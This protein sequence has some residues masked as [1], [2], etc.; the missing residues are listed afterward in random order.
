V[1]RVV[2]E[3]SQ[4]IRF[5]L[6][7]NNE[8]TPDIYH[9]LPG[10]GAYVSLDK[11]TVQM[12]MKKQAFSRAFRK[13][14][15]T[16]EVLDVMIEKIIKHSTIEALS[17]CNKAGLATFGFENVLALVQKNK[18]RVILHASEGSLRGLSK[19]TSA[20]AMNLTV[21]EHNSSE[22]SQQLN[23]PLQFALKSGMDTLQKGKARFFR[24]FTGEELHRA[25][26]RD[27]ITH[28][29]LREGQALSL[30]F[31]RTSQ[32]SHYTGISPDNET[33]TDNE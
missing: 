28:V 26:G 13:T 10:R 5:V 25:F 4:L 14:V 7:P 8:V 30:F 27:S 15:K 29:G 21:T 3:Q 9:K 22:L 1:S 16:S 19:I 2:K 12:A 24:I 31:S 23:E 20:A 18:A 11:K 33:M 17:F 6:S 32:Y